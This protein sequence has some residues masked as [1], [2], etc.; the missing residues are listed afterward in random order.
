MPTLLLIRHGETDWNRS[1]QVM[2][3][4]P[5]PLNETGEQQALACA[6]M[7]AQ[8]PIAG[9][10]TSP[11]LRA[12][13]TAHIVGRRHAAPVHHAPGLREIG[14]GNWINRYWKDL[15][16]DP[17]KRDWYLHPDRARPSGGETLCE[18]QQRAVAAVE[19]AL[20]VAQD[21][22]YVFVSH[23]DVIRAVLAHYLRL[24]L[25]ALRQARIDHAGVSGIEV[26][27]AATHLLFLNHRPGLPRLA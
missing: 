16:D 14:V 9:I 15:A 26:T 3:N 12:V 18:V 23:G 21:G 27:E 22:P 8:T 4:Q 7:L 6:E 2:G 11:V 25:N 19:Q 20:Q 17:A 24:D 13:Q 5:I 10:V 1:G